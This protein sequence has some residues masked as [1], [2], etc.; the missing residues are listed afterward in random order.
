MKRFFKTVFIVGL[1]TVGVVAV[2]HA[3]LGKERTRDAARALQSMAQGEVDDLIARQ[4][5]LKEELGKLRDDYPRQIALLKSQLAEIERRLAEIEKEQAR[6]NDIVRLC[7]EDISYLEDQQDAAPSTPGS[8]RVI[9]H[10]GS[11]YTPVEAERL[12]ARIGQTREM[13]LGRKQDLDAER[14]SLKSEQDRLG[15][16]LQA[17]TAEQAEFEAE[18]M[19]LVREIERLKRNDEMLKLAEKRRGKG[20]TKHADTMNTLE[21]VKAAVERARLE[22]EERLKSARVQPRDLDY[23]TRARA[24]E[25]QRK[26]AQREKPATRADELAVK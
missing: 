25:L 26:Q 20:C 17:V 21:Q 15:V 18:Y 11:R 2:T 4:T 10:R 7:E 12:I 3:V 23:E 9:E 1:C 13:Y 16:E 8:L 14:A 5:N 19:A 6:A 22:Q 24:L